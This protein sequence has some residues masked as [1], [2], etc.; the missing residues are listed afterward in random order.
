[1]EAATTAKSAVEDA[2]RERRKS[3]EH[4]GQKHVPRFF[5]HKNG[6]WEPKIEYASSNTL[7]VCIKILTVNTGFR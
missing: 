7:P 2:Q 3:M 1:M 4:H 6:R 5:V